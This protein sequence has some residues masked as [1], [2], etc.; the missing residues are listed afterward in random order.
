MIGKFHALDFFNDGSFYLL[1]APGHT[2]GHLCALA[3]TT[4][5]Q[6][7]EGDTF[8][9]MGGDACHHGGEFR[10]STYLPLPDSISPHPFAKSVRNSQKCLGAIFEKIHPEHGAAK[11][12]AR[13][14]WRT[15]PFYKPGPVTHN[16]ED[17]LETI[18]KIQVADAGDRVFFVMAHDEA[19]VDLVEFFPATANDWYRK[20]WGRDGK[21]RFLSDF[22]KAV[23]SG[24]EAG[25]E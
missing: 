23:E 11:V 8:I 24:Y 15:K 10:P 25:Q 7:H 13:D 19:L 1:D 12:E 21:W 2:V 3:R 18:H 17:A 5:G 16:M 20:G 4:I 22:Q 6:D 9:M 14:D